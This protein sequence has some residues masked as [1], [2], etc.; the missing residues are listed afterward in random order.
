MN[1]SFNFHLA[2]FFD[3]FYLLDMVFVDGVKYACA[4]CI[5][6]HRSSSCNHQ[7]RQLIEI[8]RKGRP[9]TQCDHCREL[10]KTHKI[11]VK[12]NCKEKAM[13]TSTALNDTSFSNTA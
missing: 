12:C 8:K 11:H 13:N 6:G 5:K 7:D 1:C 3:F 9:I 10:R 4:T 2:I